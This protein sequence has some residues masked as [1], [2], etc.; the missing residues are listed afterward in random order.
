GTDAA[1]DHLFVLLDDDQPSVQETLINALKPFGKRVVTPLMECLQSPQ[2]SLRGKETALLALARLDGVKTDQLLSF[3]ETE[4]Q[5]VYRYKLMLTLLEDAP[6]LDADTFLRIALNDAYQ[7]RLSLLVQLL[8]V[9]SSPEVARLVESGLHDTD[10]QKRAQALEALE[11]LSE[12]RF[13]RLFLPI[14]EADGDSEDS[15]REVAQQQWELS[16]TDIMEVISTCR[17]SSEKW[18]VIGALLSEQARAK[19]NE[20]WRAHLQTVADTTEDEDVRRTAQHLHHANGSEPGLALTDI[21][22]F[23]NRYPLFRSMS[24]DQLHTIAEQLVEREMAAKEVIF[25]EG[26]LSRDWYLIVSGKVDIVQQRGDTCH[27]IVTL[28]AGEFFGEMAI[29][30]ER[31]RS[32]GAVVA[33]SAK[34]LTLSPERF[35]Q[36]V[37]Q[38]P[39]ISFEIFREL[40]ARL[41]RLDEEAAAPTAS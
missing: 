14:L 37:L 17:Q 21:I 12:R 10:R 5:D 32:A 22:L 16:F 38:D 31:A 18:L 9:W 35:R 8:A 41:R 40:S 24:L 4:L 3:W 2:C 30:E 39:A 33:E 20:T 11:S 26:D 6:P 19:T 28:N 36:V 23:L 7:R 27:T 25:S 29:F 1:L 15:W 13:T 34:L